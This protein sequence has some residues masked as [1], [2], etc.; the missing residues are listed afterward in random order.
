MVNV[1]SLTTL[2]DRYDSLL[3]TL[4]SLHKQ[5]IKFDKIYLCLPYIAKRSGKKY[6]IPSKDICDLCTIVRI[7]QDYGPICKLVGALINEQDPDTIIVTVDDDVIYPP[8]FLQL[9]LEKH[10]LRPNAALTGAGVLIND[11]YHMSIN[12]NF[13]GLMFLNGFLCGFS[14]YNGQRDIDIVQGISGCLYIR[15]FFPLKDKLYEELLYLTEDQDLFLSDDIVTSSY[16][17]SK[18]IKRVTFKKMPI[19]KI[20]L[21]D[22][23]ALSNNLSKMLMT[24]KRAVKKCQ[25]LKL[26]NHLE[27]AS[28]YDSPTIK[29][30]FWFVIIILLII[31]LV[32]YIKNIQYF[33]IL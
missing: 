17:C 3:L 12:T 31:I 11:G 7:K 20:C 6:F 2:P 21:A 29:A 32:I 28:L 15:R 13:N 33:Y 30:P 5:I 27:P 25:N 23:V 24:F 26:L 16:L 18:G 8:N 1:C 22:E 9:L 4:K 10:K 19:V 14:Y